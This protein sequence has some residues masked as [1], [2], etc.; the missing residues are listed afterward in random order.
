MNTPPGTVIGRYS[1]HS[2]RL[3]AWNR[4]DVRL[5]QEFPCCCNVR[6]C[7][8]AIMKTYGLIQ[9][10]ISS[11]L[12]IHPHPIDLNSFIILQSMSLTQTWSPEGKGCTWWSAHTCIVNTFS[13]Y[14]QATLS[15]GKALLARAQAG[16]DWN[17]EP[18]WRLPRIQKSLPWCISNPESSTPK[19]L[20]KP[21]PGCQILSGYFKANLPQY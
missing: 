10:P 14:I 2:C 16:A 8:T 19:G 18:V 9:F 17:G 1:N 3:P 5:I 15:Q 6:K 21:T 7:N 12:F 4:Y 20:I 11:M 13:R